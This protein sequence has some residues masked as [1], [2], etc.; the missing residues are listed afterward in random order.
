M[1]GTGCRRV[2][3]I[4]IFSLIDGRWRLDGPSLQGSLAKATTRVL[5]LDASGTSTT[6]L[7]VEQRRHQTGLLGLWSSAA[8][9]WNRSLP[10]PLGASTTVL[11]SA[12]GATGQQL[13]L[14]GRTGS[15]AVVEE[16]AGP[17]RPWL[18]LPTPPAGTATVVPL[19]DGGADAFSVSGSRLSVFTLSSQGDWVRTQRMNVP[20]AY[21]SS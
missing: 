7:V 19:A 17:G 13:V 8:G 11:S 15:G 1:L 21:G 9:S 18:E 3:Q 14:L 20:I 5:R 16:T 2:G 12:V 6:A 10:L 4:G